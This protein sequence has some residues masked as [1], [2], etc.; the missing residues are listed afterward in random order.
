MF[1]EEYKEKFER[2]LT[3]VNMSNREF[4]YFIEDLISQAPMG[5]MQ[6]KLPP[7]LIRTSLLDENETCTNVTRCSY[8]PD[9]IKSKIPMQRCNLEGQQVFYASIPGGMRNFSDGAQPSLMETVMQ[10]IIDNPTFDARKAAVSRWQIKHQPIFWFL[11]HYTNSIRNNQHFKFLFNQFDE[12]LK[13]NSKSIEQYKNFTEKLNYLSELFCR[14][15]EKEKTYKVTAA[16]YN[17]VMSLDKPD[18]ICYDALIY[19][20][21]N[22]KG[23]GMNIVLTKDYVDQK[24]IYCDLVVLYSINRN[25]DNAKNIWFI[26]TA[27]AIPDESGNLEFKPIE[28]NLIE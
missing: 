27:Q 10:K 13:M 18:N 8:V 20:S 15:D 23:E 24:N 4:D 3:E 16:Y 5:A 21:A 28:N 14:N 19:P 11:P 9:S 26:P 22:T 2:L 6:L 12:F 1:I 7:F 25:L 17:K